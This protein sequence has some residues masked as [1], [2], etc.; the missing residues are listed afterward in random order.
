MIRP[1]NNQILAGRSLLFLQILLLISIVFPA[2]GY[3]TDF[4]LLYSNDIRGETEPC[5]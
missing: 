4:V 5:G 2:A 3:S 1:K